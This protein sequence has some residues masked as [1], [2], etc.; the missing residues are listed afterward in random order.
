M[1]GPVTSAYRTITGT[2]GNIRSAVSGGLHAAWNDVRGVGSWFTSIGSAIV[3][4]IVSG[5]ENAAGSL[6]GSLRSLASKALGAAK[7]FL[8]IG[9][10]S[11]VFAEQVGQWIPHGVAAG[12]TAHTPAAV[13]AVTTMGARLAGTPMTTPGAGGLVLAGGVGG[14][15]AGTAV[16]VNIT[17]QGSV[18]SERDLRDV[19]QTQMLR[20]GMRSSTSYTPYRR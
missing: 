16:T 15:P 6:F 18:L 3:D 8:G 13:D 7:S 9:S 11:R 1:T 14:V 12:I 20:L 19:V 4:G 2:V 5:V 17:V 10:P